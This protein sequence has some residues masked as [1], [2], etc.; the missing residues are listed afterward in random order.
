MRILS[1][2]FLRRNPDAA[3]DAV[4]ADGA[5]HDVKDVPIRRPRRRDDLEDWVPPI[6]SHVPAKEQAHA[7]VALFQSEERYGPIVHWEIE[8][9][10]AECAWVN[11]FIQITKLQLARALGSICTKVR[12]DVLGEDGCVIRAAHY[13]IPQPFTAAGY[14]P[15]PTSATGNVVPIGAKRSAIP[16]GTRLSA[17]SAKGKVARPKP[18]R[19]KGG[20]YSADIQE[21]VACQR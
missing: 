17:R 1:A 9:S 7:L 11:G 13:V 20:R 10:Y 18:E 21:A 19:R 3:V 15:S 2:I 6:P 4:D 5:C 16:N 12:L 8:A 14:K